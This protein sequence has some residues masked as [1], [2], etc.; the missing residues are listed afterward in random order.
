[1]IQ[2]HVIS[3]HCRAALAQESYQAMPLE[4][5]LK[6]TG[7]IQM[8]AMIERRRGRERLRGRVVT[9]AWLWCKK[10]PYRVS[11]RLGCA[12]L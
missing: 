11:S 9:A 1:M 10:S 7:Y 4:A 6:V 8:L 5:S 2:H 3:C 12:M